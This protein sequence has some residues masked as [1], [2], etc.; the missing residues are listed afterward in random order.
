VY[1]D[2]NSLF[3]DPAPGVPKN[4]QI[5]ANGQIHN[6]GEGQWNQVQINVGA[7]APQGQPSSPF[8]FHC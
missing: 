6:F 8:S 7:P 3:G 4:L 1:Q 2:F 5:N